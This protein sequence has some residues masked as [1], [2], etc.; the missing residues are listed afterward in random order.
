MKLRVAAT[1]SKGN[2]YI[3]EDESSRLVLDAGIPFNMFKNAVG[4][5]I[6]NIDGCLVTHGHADH[7]KAV[8]DM[9]ASGIDVHMSKGT[10]LEIF[11]PNDRLISHVQTHLAGDVFRVGPWMVKGFYTHHD[12]TEPF[13]FIL[14]HTKKSV[15][16]LYLTDTAYCEY[17][18][19]DLN[20]IIIECNYIL[21][22]INSR[23]N[24]GH[25]NKKLKSRILDSHIGLETLV[26]WLQRQ[27]LYALEKIVLVHLS[28]SN[29]DAQRM[30][31]TVQK[32]T[33]VDTITAE[34]GQ[35]IELSQ[36]GF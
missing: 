13:G 6:Q 9:V 32:V 22:I 26:P 30:R 29:S 14:L 2:C 36:L 17:S 7:A 4:F 23:V 1:G 19:P 25:L 20:F 33:G 16:G 5:N 15:K 3:I 18:F 31:G 11:E 8:S 12:A 21:D 35:L 27:N 24:S 28:D 34:A 10:M